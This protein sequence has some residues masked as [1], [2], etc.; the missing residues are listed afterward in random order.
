MTKRTDISRDWA[1][2]FGLAYSPL[3]E[4]GEVTVDGEHHVLLDG[5]YGSFALSV[6]A[7]RIWQDRT[8]ANWSW[9]SNLPHHVTVTDSEVAVVRWDKDG[10]ELFTRSSVERRID[11]FYKFL[12]ADRVKSNHRVIEHLLSIFRRI[13]SLLS[14]RQIEDEHSIEVYLA[15]LSDAL[16]RNQEVREAARIASH[17]LSEGRSI[18]NDLPGTAVNNLHEVLVN[19]AFVGSPIKM[20]PV[21]AVR[22]AGSD[23]FQ[24]AHFEMV[25][26]YSP[27]LFGYVKPAESK[28]VTRGGAHFT[29]AALARSLVEQALDNSPGLMSQSRISI[30]DPACGS[31]SFLYEALRA[32]RRACFEGNVVI[33][34]RDISNPAISMAKFVIK[35][36]LVDW[37]PQG[38]CEVDLDVADSL[39][40]PLDPADLIL[41][42]PPFVSWL[43]L[44]EEQ[45]V[46]MRDALA[47]SF[48]GRGDYSM[49]FISRAIDLLR[50]GGVI[51]TLLPASLLTLQSADNW[52]R[53]ILEK[54]ALKFLASLG[55]YGLFPYATV[56]VAAAIFSKPAQGTVSDNQ[57][58]S[59]VAKDNPYATGDALRTLRMKNRSD[60]E[61]G[62][63]NR[64]QIFQTSARALRRRATWRPIAPHT[65]TAIERALESGRVS[66]LAKLF[67]V[68]QGVRTGFNQ[69]FLL[70]DAVVSAM[71]AQ[72]RR[73]FRPAVMND[74]IKRGRIE[75]TR[76]V[77]YPY[78]QRGLAITTE[79]QLAKEVPQYFAEHLQPNRQRLMARANIVRAPRQDWWG[80]SEHRAWALSPK[81]CIV[82]K[83]FGASGGFATDF[84]MRLIVVQGFA[85]FPKWEEPT[86]VVESDQETPELTVKDALSA[87]FTVMNSSPF[88]NFL[89]VFSPHVLGGQFDLSPR[90]VNQVPIPNIP[91]LVTEEGIGGIVSQLVRLGSENQGIDAK[92]QRRADRLVSRLYGQELLDQI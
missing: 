84:A 88:Q 48:K 38:G 56:Q 1:A 3:F 12:S 44:T 68:H 85:W 4:E 29:P 55:D 67:D 36:A 47:G 27:D 62:D 86:S 80:L 79:E 18:L 46:H 26:P 66:P 28:K 34:G 50:P 14:D 9:S 59:L 76:F 45:R 35:N 92:W 43:A 32:L 58:I 69:V 51:G 13:R 89:S 10:E 24:E 71:K 21:L 91:L 73:W 2:R 65:E 78:D 60:H 41:M 11:E 90:F 52:R 5:G 33:V 63:D 30:L 7:E 19:P 70:D 20:Q 81:P 39:V 6:T 31:G 42:N 37:S 16:G 25:R 40:S 15:F 17:D 87:Y 64:W 22:H 57:V 49:A 82:S 23:V 54:V 74:T 72:E 75:P 53:D 77:F 83:Y 61:F 8:S